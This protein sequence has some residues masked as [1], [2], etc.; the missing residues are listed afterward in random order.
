MFWTNSGAWLQNIHCVK[1]VRIWSY[2]GPHFPA[3]GLNTERYCPNA[4]KMQT[5]ITP[6]TG[7][8]YIVVAKNV[9]N[10]CQKSEHEKNR[11]CHSRDFGF[12]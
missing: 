6:N 11:L 2:S 7:T 4:G 10:I 1:S 9:K 8:F 5:R 3:F 12:R